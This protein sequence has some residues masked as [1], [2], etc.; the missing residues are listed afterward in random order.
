[1][2][3]NKTYYLEVVKEGDKPQWPRPEEELVVGSQKLDGGFVQHWA[4]PK[5]SNQTGNSL[6]EA[7][8]LASK[9]HTDQPAVLIDA[10]GTQ[11]QLV[12]IKAGHAWA[13][14]ESNLDNLEDNLTSI[15]EFAKNKFNMEV[16]HFMT[17]DNI[18]EEAEKKLDDLEKTE[19]GVVAGEME[20]IR[21]VNSSNNPIDFNSSFS[22]KPAK[23]S[24][25]VLILPLI[26][27]LA[28]FGG[29]VMFRGQIFSKFGFG[30]KSQPVAEAPAP[31]P[32]ETPTPTPTVERSGFKVRVLNGTA[33]NG[34]AA[35]LGDDLKA[36]GWEI[37]KVGNATSSAIPQ[38]YIRIKPGLDKVLSTLILDLTG[39]FEATSSSNLSASDGADA[40]VVIGKK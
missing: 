21:Q 8:I 27:I 10:L 31:T 7:E 35:S 12:L 11:L 20:P 24:K 14:T 23:K 17:T 30:Q 38:T 5:D 3:E 33:Q 40:E 15:L 16:E 29:I 22:T 25:L 39:Q 34:A 13:K 19:G 32:T 4:Y 2:E 37:L 18:P 9:H 28:L 36:K 1:M 26:V 6:P